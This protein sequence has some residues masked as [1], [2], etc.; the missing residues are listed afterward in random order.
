MYSVNCLSLFE[1]LYN[2]VTI[3]PRA[4]TAQRVRWWP[5][6]VYN[7]T[8]TEVPWQ[9]LLYQFYNYSVIF[10]YTLFCDAVFVLRTHVTLDWLIWWFWSLNCYC[11]IIISVRLTLAW[12]MIVS[13]FNKLWQLSYNIYLLFQKSIVV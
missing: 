13:D 6:I 12:F 9:Q 2:R 4:R 1:L 7:P 5:I 8:R 11:E 10:L 3:I